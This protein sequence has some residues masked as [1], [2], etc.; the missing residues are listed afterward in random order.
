MKRESSFLTLGF[1]FGVLLGSLFTAGLVMTDKEQAIWKNYALAKVGE[2]L[3]TDLICL[4]N[5]CAHG[6]ISVWL[7][8]TVLMP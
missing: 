8:T 7:K 2:F 5:S 6:V 4:K 1:F 3:D